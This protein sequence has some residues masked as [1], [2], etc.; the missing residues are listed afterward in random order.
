MT[1]ISLSVLEVA[2][3]SISHTTLGC[4]KASSLLTKN[5]LRNLLTRRPLLAASSLGTHTLLRA[6]KWP[7][8]GSQAL[9]TIQESLAPISTTGSFRV[10]AIS[11][12]GYLI[13]GQDLWWCPFILDPRSPLL[14]HHTPGIS[15]GQLDPSRN[16]RDTGFELERPPDAYPHLV[17]RCQRYTSKPLYLTF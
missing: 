7:L 17:T 5:A 4:S 14:W 13:P 10:V 1:L 3:T 15:P 9:Y 16:I 11:G 12:S 6:T 2:Q 8:W